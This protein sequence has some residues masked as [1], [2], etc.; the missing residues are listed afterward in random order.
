MPGDV[1]RPVKAIRS[2]C[3]TAPSLRLFCSAKVRIVA[4]VVSAFH[5]VTD[6]S[7]AR[8][9]SISARVSGVSNAAALASIQV[10]KDALFAFGKR[11]EIEPVGYLHL[12]RIG[13]TP[14]G[15][16][17]G[18]LVYSVPLSPKEEVNITHKSGKH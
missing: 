18:E 15:I 16:E 2:G 11:L 7:A 8:S 13:F 3:A 4:S 17:R 12:E 5:D 14:V 6:S 10:A 1:V 9:L